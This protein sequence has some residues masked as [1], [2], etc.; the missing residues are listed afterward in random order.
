[1]RLGVIGC[2]AIAGWHADAVTRVDDMQICATL[3]AL[4]DRSNALA[5]R[6]GATA[7]RTVDQLADACDA[8][9]VCVPPRWHRQVAEEAIDAGLNVLVEKPVATRLA[10]GRAMVAHAERAGCLLAVAESVQHWS[11]IRAAQSA[12]AAGRIGELHSAVATMRYVPDPEFFGGGSAWRH[13]PDIA[14]GGVVMDSG[15]HY[16]R[17]LRMCAGEFVDV[18]ARAAQQTGTETSAHLLARTEHG[19]VVALHLVVAQG[20]SDPAE[21]LWFSGSEGELVVRADEVRLRDA[22]GL[23]ERLLD[24]GS[25]SYVDSF[26]AQLADFAAAVAGVSSLAAPAE[27]ALRD[28]AVCEAVYRSLRDGA[29]HVVERVAG[30]RAKVVVVG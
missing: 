5:D 18:V 2:G 26:A 16:I 29:G 9:L 22:V 13:R 4:P 15:P 12:I 14:G 24:A 6:T 8:V 11:P 21:A 10:D 1:M 27:E 28:L 19:A 7:V 30:P 17:A 23:E 20:S 25:A 3:D